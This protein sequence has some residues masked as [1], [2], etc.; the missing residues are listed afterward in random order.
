M[1]VPGHKAEALLSQLASLP[2]AI[3]L[4]NIT[5]FNHIDTPALKLVA[6][7]PHLKLLLNRLALP[8]RP[9]LALEGGLVEGGEGG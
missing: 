6:N 8:V 1:V 4:N 2:L 3:Q 5:P 7:R 9:D